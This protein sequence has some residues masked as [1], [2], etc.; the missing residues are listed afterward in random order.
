[1]AMIAPARSKIKKPP[2][3]WQS[4]VRRPVAHKKPTWTCSC[5]C[6]R[7]S[8]TRLIAYAVV[9]EVLLAV[10]ASELIEFPAPDGVE[11]DAEP[12]PPPP[13]IELPR[14]LAL[15]LRVDQNIL[16]KLPPRV[17][18]CVSLDWWPADKCDYGD[19]PW[20]MPRFRTSR[21]V[22]RVLYL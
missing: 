1:M 4:T 14:Q 6:K 21:G 17:Q 22:L 2:G 7:C 19:C 11:Q 3:A 9:T 20:R 18:S 15:R 13:P 12:S 5:P 16:H 10:L 8:W